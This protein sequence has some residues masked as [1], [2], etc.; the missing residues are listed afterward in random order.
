MARR[1]LGAFAALVAASA[2]LPA[3]AASPPLPALA[4]SPPLPAFAGRAF[5][6]ADPPPSV[7]IE[8]KGFGHGVGMAQ[9][10]AYA[11]AAAGASAADILAHFYPGTSIGRRGGTVRVDVL[12]APGPVS[13]ALPG[14]GEIR[15]AGSGAQSPGFPVTVSPGGSVQLSFAG[16]AYRVK[17]VSGAS[18]ARVAPVTAAPAPTAA[19]RAVAPAPAPATTPSTGLLDPL[20][21]ALT[22][23]TVPPP[24]TATPATTA[25]A[26]TA[27]AAAPT[28][29]VSARGLSAVPKRDSVVDLPGQD[30]RYRGTIEVGSGGGGLQLT[31]V[32]DV[33]QYVRGMGEMPASWPAAALQAQAIAA[34]TFAMRAASAGRALCDDQQCQVYLGAGNEHPAT[35]AAAVATRGRVL[36]YQGALAEALYSASGGGVSATPAEG[37]GPGSPDVSYLRAATYSTADPQPWAATVSLRQLAGRFGYRGELTG[38]RVSST[39]P[40]GRPLEITFDGDNGPL[41]VDGHRFWADLQ[42]RSTLF[43]IRPAGSEPPPGA[44]RLD[45]LI[46]DLPSVRAATPGRVFV[47]ATRPSLG[48]A[49]WIGLA[50]LLLATASL[51]RRVV[52]QRRPVPITGNAGAAMADG[53]A[54]T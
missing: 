13:V 35:D 29:A 26:A 42:L 12:S 10:G 14:G 24:R 16:G 50:V 11:M 19:P 7:V 1:S 9:D 41:V 47:A 53:S 6:A 40:S 44:E 45:A 52:T 2:P 21:K 30:R 49:P 8:G 33:E 39:G 27:A 28:E 18:L 22:P 15:E 37:F 48:R 46:P 38:V 5:Q 54:S 43:T 51:G 20:L 3:L 32:V 34:R 36:T 25:P 4:A 17:P 31:N 23:T